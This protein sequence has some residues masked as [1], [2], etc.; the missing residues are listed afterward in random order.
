MNCYP[1]ISIYTISTFN[2]ASSETFA[3]FSYR[4]ILFKSK[5]AWDLKDNKKYNMSKPSKKKK[6]CSQNKQRKKSLSFKATIL[7]NKLAPRIKTSCKTA[8]DSNEINES[9]GVW[10][11]FLVVSCGII[12]HI[13]KVLICLTIY[14]IL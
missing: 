7:V 14:F 3:K 11:K 4:Y 6:P 13:F 10:G 8:S 2:S 9:K 1:I 5:V 12:I